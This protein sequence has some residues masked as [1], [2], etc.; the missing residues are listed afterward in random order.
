MQ[1]VGRVAST[2]AVTVARLRRRLGPSNESQAEMFETESERNLAS[3]LDP[4]FDVRR[5]NTRTA[6]CHIITCSVLPILVV[7]HVQHLP[8]A[9]LDL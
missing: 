3:F 6:S 9:N 7:P 8:V 4:F 2:V 5:P 1:F